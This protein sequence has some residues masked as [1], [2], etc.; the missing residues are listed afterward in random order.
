MKHQETLDN[1]EIYD[2][3]TNAP[4]EKVV[5]KVIYSPNEGIVI[6][7]DGYGHKEMSEGPVILIELYNG[8][9]RVIV[10]DDITNADPLIVSLEG[11]KEKYR[12]GELET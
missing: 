9:L 1:I 11:A 8:D 2:V 5:A 6:Q 4:V 3:G 12:E 7:F 10:N